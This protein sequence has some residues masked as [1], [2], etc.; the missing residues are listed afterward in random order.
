[1][2]CICGGGQTVFNEYS[3]NTLSTSDDPNHQFTYDFGNTY[4]FSRIVIEGCRGCNP[5]NAKGWRVY[6]KDGLTEVRICNSGEILSK[7][8]PHFNFECPDHENGGYLKGNKI[9]VKKEG[10]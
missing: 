2:C 4:T 6:V 3:E 10:N 1:M 8:G 5:E 7:G 9:I